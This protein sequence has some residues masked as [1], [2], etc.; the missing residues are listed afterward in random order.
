MSEI[1][2]IN[3]KIESALIKIQCMKIP[4][5]IILIIFGLFNIL[6]PLF[7]FDIKNV[8]KKKNYI[9]ILYESPPKLN[10]DNPSPSNY[11]TT[12]IIV[13][14][15]FNG[16]FALLISF[17]FFIIALPSSEEINGNFQAQQNLAKEQKCGLFKV[18]FTIICI[19][20]LIILFIIIYIKVLQRSETLEESDLFDVYIKLIKEICPDK[21]QSPCK[22]KN[23]SPNV[24]SDYKN[25]INYWNLFE[26]KFKCGGFYGKEYPFYIGYLLNDNKKNSTTDLS[27]DDPKNFGCY[28]MALDEYLKIVFIYVIINV[29]IYLILLFFYIALNQLVTY[30]TTCTCF[31]CKNDNLLVLLNKKDKMEN[32]NTP[33]GNE[34]ENVRIVYVE[35][36]VETNP[37]GREIHT[38]KQKRLQVE[39]SCKSE[40]F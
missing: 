35:R 14:L 16:V 11:Y 20:F 36:P 3:K 40:E 15:V 34:K 19:I 2:Q 37:R 33:T 28:Q 27:R 17:F 7:F 23:T 39:D 10:N 24:S 18:I 30:G 4:I 6:Y 8:W 13:L 9:S 26:E 22:T 29:L 12:M 21:S 32:L 1:E 38:D 25:F 31:C 5:R